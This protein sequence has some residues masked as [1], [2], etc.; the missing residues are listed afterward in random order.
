[1]SL[2]CFLWVPLFYLLWRNIRGSNAPGG[3]WA[4]LFG[5]I[6][7]LIQFFQGPLVEPG[8]FGLSRWMSGLVDIVVF[9]VVAPILVYLL[10]FCLK[11]ISGTAD[12]ASFALL[13]LIPGSILRALNWSAQPDPIL[14]ILVPI[15]WTAIAV[16]I[17]FFVTIILNS[18]LFGI[19]CSSFG[20]LFIP[21]AAASS[22]WAFF[23]QL[24]SIGFF[25]LLA[26][27]TPMLVSMI[28]GFL[29]AGDS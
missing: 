9:P 17:Q 20:I 28:L 13:W 26:A 23:S 4:V 25:F 10:L 27:A 1:M 21:F 22:Y 2:F 5:C 11:L 29:R 7:A 8:G 15:L 16:G 12:F 14:L 24:T 3:V 6:V 18:R 19:I